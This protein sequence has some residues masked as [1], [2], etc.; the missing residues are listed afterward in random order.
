MIVNVVMFVLLIVLLIG[1]FVMIGTVIAAL[2]NKQKELRFCF[3]RD[4]GCESA[5]TWTVK[6]VPYSR[7]GF[8]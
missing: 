2:I 5:D 8:D 7:I 4:T 1:V 6:T 3:V